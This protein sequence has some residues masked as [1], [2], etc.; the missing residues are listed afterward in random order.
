MRPPSSPTALIVLPSELLAEYSSP[1]S[2][3][4]TDPPSP[5]LVASALAAKVDSLN[6]IPGHLFKE[7][8]S[9]FPGLALSPN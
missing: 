4:T 7:P 5:P 8:L 9:A 1:S 3:T 2:A 6:G